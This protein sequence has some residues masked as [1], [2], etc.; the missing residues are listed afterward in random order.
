MLGQ[1]SCEQL[2]KNNHEKP[3]RYYE[4]LIIAMLDYFCSVNACTTTARFYS[5]QYPRLY[6]G[7]RG[8]FHRGEVY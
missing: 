1:T 5:V 2:G 6:A 3:Q 4:L 8:S 7:N